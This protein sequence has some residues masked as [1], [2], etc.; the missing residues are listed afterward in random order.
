MGRAVWR[1]TATI[2]AV[3][4]AAFLT[5]WWWMSRYADWRQSVG[6]L[7]IL[8][9]ALPDAVFVRY[10]VD[11]KSGYWPLAMALSLLMSSAIVAALFTKTGRQ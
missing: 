7:V 3:R 2:A 11:P 6:Y 5:G 10:V 4:L 9:G 1:W 8:A